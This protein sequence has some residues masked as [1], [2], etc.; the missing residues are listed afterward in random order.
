MNDLKKNNMLL[1]EQARNKQ[2]FYL[3]YLFAK[4]E[5]EDER[6]RC[7]TIEQST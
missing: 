4:T 5:R 3:A 6:K 2:G 1:Y 7:K